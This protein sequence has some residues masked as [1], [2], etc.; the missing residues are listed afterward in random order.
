MEQTL[1]DAHVHLASEEFKDDIEQVLQASYDN[2]V[3]T[4]FNVTTNQEELETSFLYADKYPF[5]KF[6][7]IAGGHPHDAPN[8]GAQHYKTYVREQVLK[9]RLAAIGEIGLDYGHCD[10]DIV[11]AQKRLFIDYLRLAL[12]FHLSVVVHCRNAFD[13]FFDL[14]NNEYINCRHALPGML[15]CFSGSI[16][17]ARK[18]VDRGWF[19]SLSGILTFKNAHSLRKTAAYIPI[20]NLLVETDAPFLAPGPFRGK[21]NEPRHLTLTAHTLA[22]VKKITFGDVVSQT[23]A[24]ALR[25]I[26][27]G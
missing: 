9:G 14:I 16:E 7:H 26:A 22:E 6:Y 4:V 1:V 12:E 23:Q 5:M 3:K 18:L 11:E 15:H 27:K 20:E 13:D 19:V 21:R 10:S 2:G 24:N 8:T 17:D 25:F